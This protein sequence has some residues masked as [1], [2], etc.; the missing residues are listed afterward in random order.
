MTTLNSLASGTQKAS[1]DWWR[2]LAKKNE[3][4]HIL[5][6]LS[7]IQLPD[8]DKAMI[9]IWQEDP[10]NHPWMIWGYKEGQ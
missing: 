2:R 10:L 5:D 7:Q 3:D 9:F 8:I 4:M 1:W 6:I